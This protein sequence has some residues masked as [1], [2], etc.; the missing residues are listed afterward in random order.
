MPSPIVSVQDCLGE[1]SLY[2]VLHTAHT[3]R[4]RPNQA[5]YL[6]L[7]FGTLQSPYAG[8]LSSG[9]APSGVILP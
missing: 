8:L 3:A 1:S 2:S 4:S 5:K 9:M 7:V 6:V